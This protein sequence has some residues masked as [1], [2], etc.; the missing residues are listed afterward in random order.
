MG[1]TGAGRS[2]KPGDGCW[3]QPSWGPVYREPVAWQV[4]SSE[5][6][7]LGA[8]G[9]I[10]EATCSLVPRRC[11]DRLW[12]TAPDR[13]CEQNAAQASAD[14]SSKAQEWRCGVLPVSAD[15]EGSCRRR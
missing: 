6:D 15:G 10:R 13:E 5:R 14:D 2:H 8:K 7:G 11:I 12:L 9:A 4:L 1:Y 3:G